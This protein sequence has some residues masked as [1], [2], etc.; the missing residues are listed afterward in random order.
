MLL[1]HEHR[2]LI[3]TVDNAIW[4]ADQT[5]HSL[6]GDLKQIRTLSEL[7]AMVPVVAAAGFY[8]EAVDLNDMAA[9]LKSQQEK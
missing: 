5:N 9:D 3:E 2:Q 6:V 4:E 7:T 8:P 1:E